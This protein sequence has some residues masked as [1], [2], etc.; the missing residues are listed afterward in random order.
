M[1]ERRRALMGSDTSWE[2]LCSAGI[3][4]NDSSGGYNYVTYIWTNVPRSDF[5]GSSSKYVIMPQDYCYG[6]EEY[7]AVIEVS[8][9]NGIAPNN[10]QIYTTTSPTTPPPEWASG[11]SWIVITGD[12][13]LQSNG[14]NGSNLTNTTING[15]N[16]FYLEEDRMATIVFT[17]NYYPD[18]GGSG[19]P[20]EC[21]WCGGGPMTSSTPIY[22]PCWYCG[23]DNFVPTKKCDNC[24]NY[25]AYNTTCSNCGS[26][27]GEAAIT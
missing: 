22:E 1:D 27:Y 4:Y 26:V 18:G 11:D 3:D 24:G 25:S 5:V 2:L 14:W 20:G 17:W 16:A 8:D 15:I 23:T 21:L 19:T 6:G 12:I 10:L 13:V 9:R 7:E